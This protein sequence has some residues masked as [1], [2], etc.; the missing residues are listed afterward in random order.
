M[1]FHEIISKNRSLKKSVNASK[2]FQIG[3]LNNITL[4]ALPAYLEYHL[5]NQS[6][7]P[8]ITTGDYD[9]I[10]QDSLR[11]SKKDAVIIFWELSNIVDGFHH[12][13]LTMSDDQLN[14]CVENLKSQIKLTIIN[15]T[16]CPLVVWNKFNTLAFNNSNF[17][18]NKLDEVCDDLNEFLKVESTPNIQLIDLCR[19]LFNLGYDE[20][21]N[22]RNFYSARELYSS[23]FFHEY[24]SHIAPILNA[25]TGKTKKA[26]I[27]DCDNTL[28]GGVVGEDG[29]E[30][31][32]LSENDNEGKIYSE[33][34][35]YCNYLA[36]QGIILGL[37]SKNNEQDVEEVFKKRE[38]LVLNYEKLIIKK[39]NWDSKTK[40]LKSIAKTLNIGIDSIVFLD[41]SDFE[42]N[43]IKSEIPEIITIQVPEIKG[44]YPT[45][46]RSFLPY[47]RNLSQ[48]KEDTN[49]L[50]M[51]KEQALRSSDKESFSGIEEYLKSLDIKLTIGVDPE[52]QVPRL[53]QMT[54]KTNQFNLT[55]RRYTES[56]VQKFISSKD[57]LV[58]SVSV[59]DKFGSSGITGLAIL[60]IKDNIAYLDTFLM[61]CRI[62][63]RNIE[64][65]FFDQLINKL[66]EI[67]VKEVRA[68]YI[69][70]TKNDQVSDIYDRLSFECVENSDEKKEYNLYIA[71]YKNNNIEYINVDYGS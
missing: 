62:I 49:R 23:T 45:Y 51:Y 3:I 55:T 50:K 69:Q 2:I 27:L 26:L 41:D 4:N 30:G 31:I 5:L 47:F 67:G 38:D 17:F 54:Q 10:I 21:F 34:Q 60:V 35:N 37:A 43:L 39:V 57:Y 52:N 65:V 44:N 16:D 9:N 1:K 6:V 56:E 42:V 58:F 8:E 25:I 29:V 63:G 36:S 20:A 33:I 46:F 28:W 7:F 15:L 70:T 24:S 12:K 64:Y 68:E 61:S 22:F 40:N 19:P 18:N 13:C 59:S 71:D 14:D 53:A 11:F 48:T 32:K 66:S